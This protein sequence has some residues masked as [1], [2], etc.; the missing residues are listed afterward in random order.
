MKKRFKY[1]TG[2]KINFKEVSMF[3]TY[4]FFYLLSYYKRIT[5]ECKSATTRWRDLIIFAATDVFGKYM[6]VQSSVYNS[7]NALFFGLSGTCRLQLWSRGRRRRRYAYQK[8]WCP[9]VKLNVARSRKI[10]IFI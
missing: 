3:K 9:F 1:Q 6:R 4:R 2:N 7:D 5:V 10:V 8:C